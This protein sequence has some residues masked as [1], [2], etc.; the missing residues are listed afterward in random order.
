M[1][2]KYDNKKVQTLFEDFELMAKNKG[3]K[4]TR[5]IKKRYNELL[6]ATTFYEYR[7]YGLG[8]PHPLTQN[9]K[10]LYAVWVT[11]N[12]RLIIEPIAKDLSD[13]ELMK[14]TEVIIKGAE[15]YHGSKTTTYIP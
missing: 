14:C 15:D 9:K 3:I 4:T 7:S 13:E 5:M 12:I 10:G 8:K 11:N 1:K 6:A 2:I